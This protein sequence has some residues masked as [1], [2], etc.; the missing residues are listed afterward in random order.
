MPLLA[1][2]I[3]TMGTISA[4]G[5][6]TN[7]ELNNK[8]TAI[9]INN[10]TSPTT[11]N[12][13]TAKTSGGSV[14]ITATSKD[15]S[16]PK[17]MSMDP[18]N[19][20]VNVPLN[21]IIKV[22]FSE[23]IKKS[24]VF[25]NIQLRD[26][27]GSLVG[28]TKTISG[29]VLMLQKMSGTFR[30]G[31]K[32]TLFIPINSVGDKSGNAVSTS[33][34]SSFTTIG[35]PYL[36][37]ISLKAPS[38]GKK[39]KTIKVMNTIKNQGTANSKSCYLKFFLTSTKSV[40]GAKYYM[41][42]RLLTK[43]SPGVYKTQNTTCMI[44]KRVPIGSYF[45][46]AMLGNTPKYYSKSKILVTAPSLYP[47]GWTSVKNLIYYSQPNSYSCGPSS[48]KMVLSN[49]NLNL[50]EPWIEKVAG[51]SSYGGTSH[52]GLINAVSSVNQLYH[53][54][55]TAWDETFSSRNWS[56]L[57][58]KFI[59]KNTPV[60]LHVHS[61]FNA[62]GGHYVVLTG[63]NMNKKMAMVAD[64]SYG[65]YRTVSFSELQ[66]RMQWVVDTGRTSKPLIAIVNNT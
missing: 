20:A 7:T 22:T 30:L 43:T 28:T 64:P 65:G 16:T 29:R 12:T 37:V 13:S 31:T 52:Y 15:I 47:D 23:D 58:S 66:N 25:T 17:I 48:L 50:S 40:M 35:V 14:Q 54:N 9:G 8:T 44:S 24:T 57:Y 38:I 32:Y 59:S 33:Y 6:V 53:T 1:V 19:Y 10:I 41:G 56:G 62:N 45:I 18:K 49:Y 26:K 46:V 2:I 55:F 60:I 61:W 27:N 4:T 3:L 34:K 11:G 36:K 21:K 42:Q 39:G 5:E 63:L 51:S